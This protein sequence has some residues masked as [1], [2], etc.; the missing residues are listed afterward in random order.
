MVFGV[1]SDSDLW[2]E[3]NQNGKTVFLENHDEWLKK[4]NQE[5]PHLNVYEI[6]YTN[7]GYEA[8]KLMNE[9]ILST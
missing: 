6:Q 4:V 3:T 2:H 1:G 8:D 9:Y 7:N 5:S